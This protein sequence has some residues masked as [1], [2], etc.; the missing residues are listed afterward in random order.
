MFCQGRYHPS[1]VVEHSNFGGVEYST[2]L[3]KMEPKLLWIIIIFENI[4]FDLKTQNQIKKSKFFNVIASLQL[5][6][7]AD[8]ERK[9]R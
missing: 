9:K 4:S 7:A 8:D 5:S 3:R 6:T 2:L 1:Q